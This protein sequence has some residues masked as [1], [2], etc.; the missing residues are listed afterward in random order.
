MGDQRIRWSCGCQGL[1]AML[2]VGP[3][4]IAIIG[5]N[6]RVDCNAI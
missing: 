3:A 2:V 5:Q 1:V 6:K 4:G